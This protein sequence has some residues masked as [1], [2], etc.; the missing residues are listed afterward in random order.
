MDLAKKE[1]QG[2][3]NWQPYLKCQSLDNH[4]SYYADHWPLQHFKYLHC[5]ILLVS[6]ANTLI[7]AIQT[8]AFKIVYVANEKLTC[9]RIHYTLNYL[10]FMIKTNQIKVAR[11][12]L[13][14]TNIFRQR[15]YFVVFSVFLPAC[16]MEKF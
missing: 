14:I 15:I 7:P 6:L 13:T 11:L 5:V 2:K 9:I 10:F 12:I 3:K 1:S 16:S 4:S 8:T